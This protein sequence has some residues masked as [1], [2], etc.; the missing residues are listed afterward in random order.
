MNSPTAVVAIGGNALLDGGPTATIAEQFE[1][2][3]R[4]ASGLC[5]LVESGWRLVVTHGNGPQVGFIKRRS[6]LVADLAPELPHL[7]L[8]MCVADSQGSIGYILGSTL[9][10]ELRAR[11]VPGQV[12]AVLTHTVV[13]GDDPA[14]GRPS[15]PIGSFYSAADARRLAHEHRWTIV[16]DSGRGWRR[17]VP[18]PRPRRFLEQH[19]V[20]DLLDAGHVVIAAGG[21]GIPVVEEAD[22]RY[23]GVEAVIDK[24]FASALL[25]TAVDAEVLVIATGVDRIAVRFGHPDQRF[26]DRLDAAQARRHLA[27]GEFPAGSMGP[28]IEAALGFL[29]A[30]GRE[31]LVTSPATMAQAWAGGGGTRIASTG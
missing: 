17:V 14:F 1:A 9:A 6:D 3:R 18:S 29:D 4:I 7:G 5:E 27:D 19:A 25:G 15:K 20:R 12:A 26:L 8:D 21:G 30:G 24:D 11:G 10:G 23:R 2:A 28:K 31:V 22:G 13:D 16:E